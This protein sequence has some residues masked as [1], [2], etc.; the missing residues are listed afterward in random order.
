MLGNGSTPERH[1]QPHPLPGFHKHMRED[2]SHKKGPRSTGKVEN[3]GQLLLHSVQ[4][5]E[6]LLDTVRMRWG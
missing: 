1:P 3:K 2:T 6:L 4:Y 5:T